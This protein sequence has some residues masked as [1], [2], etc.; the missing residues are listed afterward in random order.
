MS[1]LKIMSARAVKSAV[2]AIGNEFTRATGQVLSFDFAPVGTLEARLAA[3]SKA[4]VLILSTEALARL[5]RSL[6]P[7]SGRVLGRT[8]IGVAVRA[9]ASEPDIATA[10]AFRQMLLSARSIAVSDVAVGGTAGKHLAQLFERMGIAGTIDRKV[11]RRASGG[12]VA[13]CVADGEAEVGMTFISEMLPIAGARV[14][15]PLPD[16][17]GSTT[18]Y[19]A[20]VMSAG[21][22]HTA[23]AK[24]ITALTD[25]AWRGIWAG[26]GFELSGAD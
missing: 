12:D 24:F 2:S 6:V 23:A 5:E 4:D 25:P 3:G 1:V 26:A 7:G 19:A 16:S 22:E 11:L 21:H 8:S 20:A 13:Q 9:G 17:L 18:T 14:V 15:G 10:E